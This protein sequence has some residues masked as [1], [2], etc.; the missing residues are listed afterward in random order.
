MLRVIARVIQLQFLALCV[1]ILCNWVAGP[2]DAVLWFVAI[3]LTL[4]ALTIYGSLIRH[5]LR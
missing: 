4:L 1:Y 5:R 2:K 3:S